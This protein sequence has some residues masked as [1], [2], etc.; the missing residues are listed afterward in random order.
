MQSLRKT[1]ATATAALLLSLSLATPAL[2]T[3]PT[4]P[5]NQEKYVTLSLIG[6]SYTA[7]NGAGLY[8]GPKES[9]RSMRNWGHVYADKLNKQGVHTTV[10]NLAHSGV[11]TDMVLKD[12][13]SKVPTD[14]DIVLFTVGG[15]DIKFADIVTGCFGDPLFLGSYAKCTKAMDFANENLDATFKRVKSILTDLSKR[16]TPNAQIVLVGYPLLSTPLEHIWSKNGFWSFS[17][18]EK[19]DAA[20]AVRDFGV[21]AAE[22]Q[23][24]LIDSWNSDPALQHVTFVPTHAKF[25]EHEP[26][27]RL[28]HKNPRRWLNELFE[29]EG[30]QNDK[31]EIESTTALKDYVHFYHPNITGHEEIGKLVYEKIGVPSSARDKESYARPIDLTFVVESSDDTKAKLPEI[32]KQMRRIAQQTFDAAK[33]NGNE[34]PQKNTRFSLVTYSNAQPPA[35]VDAPTSLEGEVAPATEPAEADDKKAVSEKAEAEPQPEAVAKKKHKEKQDEPTVT[36]GEL[37]DILSQVSALDTTAAPLSDFFAATEKAVKNTGWRQE[38]RKIVVVI[39]DAETTQSEADVAKKVEELLLKAFAANTAELNLIDL[40]KDRTETMASLFTRTGGRIQLL[41]DLRPLILEAPTAKL[42]ML[43]IQKVGTSIE[44]NADGS[45]SPNSD[46]VRYEWDF[47]GDGQTDESTTEPKVT[48][49]YSAEYSG[50]VSVKVVD[51]DDQFAIAS[52]NIAITRDGDSIAEPHDNC[53]TVPNEDQLDTDKDGIGDACDPTPL[54][55]APKAMTE[56]ETSK[57]FAENDTNTTE[58]GTGETTTRNVT[59][60]QQDP[61]PVTQP[62]ASSQML[63]QT[64]ATILGWTIGALILVA[65]GGAGMA[66]ARRQSAKAAAEMQADAA[67]TRAG[68]APQA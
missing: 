10:H 38:A 49:T 55:D 37:K 60:T 68:E 52:I 39:S 23:A 54:G 44:F 11:T 35:R 67:Q 48:H 66:F 51:Q 41:G 30:K 61:T 57:L 50:Q 5:A 36:F 58:N 6:D 24:E 13:I 14:T 16:L 29:T 42:G 45:L 19:F 62:V 64:G 40:D 65:L 27:P 46:I 26:D 7:G 34:N 8:Y 43:S 22:K 31:G 15:N 47:N 32:K 18:G 12:Q 17:S 59:Q 1:C 53:P 63:S 28:L 56:P 9:Y 33:E 21:K 20:K 3:E 2:A 25:A 4:P